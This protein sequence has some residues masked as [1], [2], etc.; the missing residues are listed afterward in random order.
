[1]GT[2][3]AIVKSR[4][5]VGLELVEKPIPEYGV[6]DVLI[7]IRKNFS[8]RYGFLKIKGE[9]AVYI[10]ETSCALGIVVKRSGK[11]HSHISGGV[12]DITLDL[13]GRRKTYTVKKACGILGIGIN[14]KLVVY[15]K[16]SV[17]CE[18]RS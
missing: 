2:M 4:P 15:F 13:H 18:K 17:A 7:K 14:V 10:S 6:N 5:G 11:P 1:M 8:R 16:Q 12:G 9:T 3:K